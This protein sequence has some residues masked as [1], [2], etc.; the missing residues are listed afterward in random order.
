MADES[1]LVKIVLIMHN[2]CSRADIAH[3][4]VNRTKAEQSSRTNIA[5]SNKQ[6]AVRKHPIRFF[7]K[8]SPV[9]HSGYRTL[10][11]HRKIIACFDQCGASPELYP[12]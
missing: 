11:F 7:G 2:K 9:L 1:Y 6:M 12:N 4:F 10:L 3:N 8:I 5:H